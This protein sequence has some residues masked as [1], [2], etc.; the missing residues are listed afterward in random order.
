MFTA[1]VILGLGAM[2]YNIGKIKQFTIFALLRGYLII[3][4]ARI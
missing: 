4:S 1:S 3:A 2:V